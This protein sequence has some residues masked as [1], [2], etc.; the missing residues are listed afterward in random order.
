M[1]DIDDSAARLLIQARTEAGLSQRALAARA[2]TTQAAV[3]RIEGGRT[4]PTVSTLARLVA[5]AG[6]DLHFE[7][8][9][10]PQPDATIEAYKRDIDRTL[11]RENL[12]KTV[13]ERVR[14][15]TSLAR[16]ATEARRAGSAA[17]QAARR[18]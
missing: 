9:V 8:V 2:R 18:R 3:A 15:L 5:A 7:L 11:L 14:S 4:K 1:L 12:R 10:P 6:F 17:K 16:F 13:D